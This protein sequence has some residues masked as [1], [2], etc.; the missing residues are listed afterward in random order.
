MM[1]LRPL[2]FLLRI[3]HQIVSKAL[4]FLTSS[5]VGATLD[6]RSVDPDPIRQFSRW[7]DAASFSAMPLPNAV[8]VATSTKEGT[9]SARVMLLKGFDERGFVFYT[10]YNSRKSK[11]I[12]A[13][14]SVA[15]V[16]YW[17]DLL[18]QVRIE[19][20]LEKTS[21]EESER[22]FR[23][24]PRSSQIGA[25]ASAQS[26]VVESREELDR[27]YKEVERR[28][29]GQRIPLPPY[30]GGYRLKP[31]R[32]E[33]WQNQFAR[34]HDRVVYEKMSDGRWEIRRLAP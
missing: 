25:W 15:L 17:P 21:P 1:I 18:R 29:S 22:Y 10:N 24:R 4:L 8:V 12:E 5:S 31:S 7:F 11:E 6:E 9:A 13:N 14:P 27:K 2:V 23:S 33:F 34:L 16:F 26:E 20:A 28:F 3:M 19:G 30:W 32:F